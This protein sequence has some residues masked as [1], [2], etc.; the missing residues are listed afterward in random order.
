[1]A[2]VALSGIITP[3]N[4]VTA[5]ST[6]TLTN[7]TLTSP[8]LTTPQLGTPASGVLTNTTGLPL[9]TG[10]TG[11]LPVT[12]L[13]SGTSASASTFW[14]GDGS[15]AAASVTPAGSTTQLQYNNAGALGAI[16]GV[17]TDGTRITASTTIGVGGATPST[18]GSGITF[19]ATQ[20]A[21]TNANT[22]D[23]YE[24]GS[25]TPVLSSTGTAPT[26]SY[27]F[28]SGK[29]VKIGKQVTIYG[30]IQVNSATGG[31]GNMRISGLPF[32]SATD[33]LLSAGMSAVNGTLSWGSGTVLVFAIPEASTLIIPYAQRSGAA[34]V[35]LANGSMTSTDQYISFSITYTI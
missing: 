24:E 26:V 9:S 22:L 13:N 29:Y 12:N 8:I 4:V 34:E 19:P 14:R 3:S 6:T 32:E 11:N 28:R 21:S 15:W 27:S 25:W 5:T 2:T 20:S 35:S 30:Y 16:T 18:S 10:V 7:K 31:T 17:T 23:D 1:M 33:N